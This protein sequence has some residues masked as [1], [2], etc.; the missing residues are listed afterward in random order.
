MN[1]LI[2]AAGF[3][4]RLRPLTDTM[5]KALV[6][7]AGRPMLEHQILKLKAEGF[8]HIVVNV[9]HFGQQIIDFIGKNHSFGIRIDISDEREQLLDTGGAVRQ[10]CR[11]FRGSCEPI[12]VHNVDVFSNAPLGKLY[13][14]YTADCGQDAALVVSKRETSRYLA[15]NERGRL[16][17]WKNVKTGEVKAPFPELRPELE[18]LNYSPNPLMP[19]DKGLSLWAFS[20]IH[21]IS[22]TLAPKLESFGDVFSIIDFYLASAADHNA[23]WGLTPPSLRLVDAGKPDTLPLAAEL[24]RGTHAGE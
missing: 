4:T 14:A 15:F 23:I 22:P 9:H 3:G 12:L 18:T 10:A 21:I 16:V 13:A 24:I 6:P 2:L 19:D 8:D 17:G 5:P 1:A 7:I 11:F 20:G